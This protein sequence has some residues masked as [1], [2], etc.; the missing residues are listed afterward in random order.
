MYYQEIGKS[1]NIFS[2]PCLHCFQTPTEKTAEKN[3]SS[4]WLDAGAWTAWLKCLAASAWRLS[5]A[6]ADKQPL[7]GWFLFEKC[8]EALTL[9]I[10]SKSGYFFWKISDGFCLWFCKTLVWLCCQSPD[11]NCG[12]VRRTWAKDTGGFHGWAQPVA[13]GLSTGESNKW[14]FNC[15][16]VISFFPFDQHLQHSRNHCRIT[17]ITRI[18]DGNSVIFTSSDPPVSVDGCSRPAQLLT[19]KQ[20]REISATRSSKVFMSSAFWC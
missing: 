12:W 5:S 9:R 16:P 3:V 8:C 18:K 13:S 15:L 11:W 14:N 1:S 6:M 2:H 10:V 19:V 7:C 20:E 4:K 17:G